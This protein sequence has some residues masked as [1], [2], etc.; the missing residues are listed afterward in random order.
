MEIGIGLPT[1][2]PGT[3]AKQVLDWAKRSEEL[4]FASLGTLDRI[5]YDNYEPLVALERSRPSWTGSG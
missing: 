5:V 1:A 4:G 3:T 2:I